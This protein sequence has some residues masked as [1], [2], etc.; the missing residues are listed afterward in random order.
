MQ[1]WGERSI[2]SRNDADRDREQFPGTDASSTTVIAPLTR[3][4]VCLIGVR[5]MLSSVF[6]FRL[7][8]MIA[9]RT[10]FAVKRLWVHSGHLIAAPSLLP[11]AMLVSVTGNHDLPTIRTRALGVLTS[12]LAVPLCI[13]TAKKIV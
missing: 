2:P 5:A 6:V 8:A 11:K 3:R 10:V 4:S 9:T 12:V 7:L 1:R 13:S